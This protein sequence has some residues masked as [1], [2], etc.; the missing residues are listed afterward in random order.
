MAF[1][2]RKSRMA[3]VQESTEGTPA[4]PTAGTDF[5]ALQDGFT[6]ELAQD[7]L[8]NA[9]L[10]ASIGASKSY[11][12]FESPTASIQ[13][14]L[15]HSGTEGQAPQSGYSK[16]FKAAYGEENVRAVQQVTTG[17]S[18]STLLKV[19]STT[20][21]KVGEAVLIK[22]ASFP[23]EIR[24]IKS[25]PNSTDLVLNFA[26]E[27]I[28][29][30][31]VGL[32]KAVYYRA[33]DSGHPT[34]T[35][36]DYRGN[37][38]ATQ[39][40]SGARVTN[41]SVDV[42][43]GEL[44]NCSFDMEG[45][46]NFF[47]PITVESGVNDTI[48]FSDGSPHTVTLTAKTYKDPYDFASAVQQ[49]MDA[50][51]S[52]TI[53]CT[54]SSYT[55]KFTIESNGAT[56]SLVWFSGSFPAQTAGGLLGFNTTA[57]DTGVLTY[58]SDYAMDYS[59]PYTPSFDSPGDALV[60]KNN[61]FMIGTQTDNVCFS[62]QTFNYTMATPKVDELSLCSESGKS[63]SLVQSRQVT[64]TATA[65]LP[66]YKADLFKAMRANDTVAW[67][68]A[69]GTKTGVNWDAG[70]SGTLHMKDCSVVSH[71]LGDSD[72][73][74]TLEFEIRGYVDSSANSET[75]LNLL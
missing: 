8:D 13:H 59:S 75:G 11:T 48:E 10:K 25:I 21:W 18:T 37:G 69:F 22:H 49:A 7:T 67:Q 42:T 52:D 5:L 73:L 35:L 46:K 28:T 50:A 12:G 70:K 23:W 74:V 17:G 30:S 56:L 64:V 39:V 3:I 20:T 63:G 60:A 43:A 24:V 58:T 29:A 9:E 27:N 71:V 61:R 32:G 51:S 41:L 40:V 57:D 68:F 31:G 1:Q 44:I 34:L 66:Q 54:Y 36:W 65:N 62:V 72:G 16:L 38:G 45:I 2:T 33:V 6:V 19:A 47:D 15:R 55:G 26:T 53:T 4:K 14:Y